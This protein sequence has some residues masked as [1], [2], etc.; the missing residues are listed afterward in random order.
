MHSYRT[1]ASRTMRAQNYY[2]NHFSSPFRPLT[3]FVLSESL[4]SNKIPRKCIHNVHWLSN[5]SVRVFFSFFFFIDLKNGQSRNPISRL[6]M[7]F[8]NFFLRSNQNQTIK[9]RLQ[10]IINK[11]TTGERL[12]GAW[13]WWSCSC[14][15]RILAPLGTAEGSPWTPSLIEIPFFLRERKERNFVFDRYKEALSRCLEICLIYIH[16]GKLLN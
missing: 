9:K 1:S 13:K 5:L 12:P 3:Q 16:F 8:L 11:Q 10:S 4:Y 2:I 6:S 7:F 15:R 14:R